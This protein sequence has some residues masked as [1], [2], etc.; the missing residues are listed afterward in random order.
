VRAAG[1]FEQKPGCPAAVHERL[2]AERL[3][4]L[5][6]DECYHPGDL[7]RRIERIEVVRIRKQRA[8][9]EPVSELI[10][11]PWRVFECSGDRDGCRVSFADPEPAGDRE[12]VYYVRALQEPTPAVN[13][14]PMR[15][16][17]DEQGRC[18][19]A[20]ACSAAGPRFDASDDCL[21]DVRERAWSSPIFV[22]RTGG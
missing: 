10:E 5:C 7:R 9:G 19:A 4:R 2:G 13:G 15:C 17:R 16:E 11:D 20:R 3:R 1:A 14:D 6:L 12:T 22:R 8:P 18:V 21:A